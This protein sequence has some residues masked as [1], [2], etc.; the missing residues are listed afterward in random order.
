MMAKD[1]PSDTVYV[2]LQ[3]AVTLAKQFEIGSVKR[4][5]TVLKQ[6]YPN[7]EKDIEKAIQLW[8]NNVAKRAEF[9]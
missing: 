8:A 1:E 4:L 5:R 3:S 7:N 9:Q 2:I 6:H